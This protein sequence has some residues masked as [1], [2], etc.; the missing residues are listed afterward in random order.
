M[1]KSLLLSVALFFFFC[2]TAQQASFRLTRALRGKALSALIQDILCAHKQAFALQ[3]KDVS[4]KECLSFSGRPGRLHW[5]GAAAATSASNVWPPDLPVSTTQNSQ[6]RLASS[7][8]CRRPITDQRCFICLIDTRH[9]SS[10]TL[11][12]RGSLS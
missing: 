4:L 3:A 1:H 5:F 9:A 7:R 8:L 11:L 10:Q 6:F 12:P 2:V